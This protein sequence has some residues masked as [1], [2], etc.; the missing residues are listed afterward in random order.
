MNRFLLLLGLQVTHALSDA[1]FNP[2]HW[3]LS[4]FVN[5]AVLFSAASLRWRNQL[6]ET[7]LYDHFAPA[8]RSVFVVCYGFA[9]FS[10]LNSDFLAM[11][12]SCA[13]ELAQL[14]V[15]ASPWLNSISVP[16]LAGW[17]AA[18]CECAVALLLL[19]G[20]TRRFGIVIGVLFHT[21][22]V[23]SPAIAVFDFSTT[24]YAMLFLFTSRETGDRIQHTID[25]VVQQTPS[26]MS[27]LQKLKATVTV[28]VAA[29]LLGRSLLGY[30][31]GNP[32]L[33]RLIWL[34]NMVVA[35]VVIGFTF[36]R[37]FGRSAPTSN[38][39]AFRPTLRIQTLVVLLAIMNGVCPYLGLKTQGS[40]TMFS[41]L[42]TEAGHWNHLVV[43]PRFRV[44]DH[45]QDN[46][47]HVAQVD[48]YRLR[49]DFV[50]KDCLVPRFEIQRAIAQN[51]DLSIT[52]IKSGQ[53]VTLSP[54]AADPDLGRP[55]N[56]LTRKIMIFRPVTPDGSPY[57][58]N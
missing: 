5:S 31:Y 52:V 53:P 38:H 2:D 15:A 33:S 36:A 50:E 11:D 4:F 27:L 14:Q 8:A 42:R 56:W 46:L 19:A 45:Y 40:F 18:I 17:C 9:A 6:D 23:I 41:N 44:F 58:G 55:T 22:L 12:S 13:C 29:F 26:L 3:L 35:C 28:T 37:L 30:T 21:F 24:V 48:D 16:S 51:P 10:K 43:P 34:F 49:A 47:W 7:R 25:H 57:C 1:P 39:V 32:R 54:A 20:R